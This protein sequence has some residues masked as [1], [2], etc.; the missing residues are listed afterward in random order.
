VSR[1]LL[2]TEECPE[3]AGTGCQLQ[4]E[5]REKE[6]SKPGRTITGK[7]KKKQ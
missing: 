1:F 5:D 7:T 3:C 2:S 6:S 4:G